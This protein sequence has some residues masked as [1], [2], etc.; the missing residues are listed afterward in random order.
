MSP[1]ERKGVIDECIQVIERRGNMA[2]QTI[3]NGEASY[4]A[5]RAAVTALN[6]YNQMVWDLRSLK[7]N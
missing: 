1:D 2:A 5:R 4:S 6:F 3:E 7:A